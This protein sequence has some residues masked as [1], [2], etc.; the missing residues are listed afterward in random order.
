MTNTVEDPTANSV[1]GTL[2]V[3]HTGA[4]GTLCDGDFGSQDV[5][6]RV[7]SCVGFIKPLVNHCPYNL[8][9][10]LLHVSCLASSYCMF[11]NLKRIT[12]RILHYLAF[13]SVCGI[14]SYTEQFRSPY[15][16]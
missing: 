3:F 12:A 7:Q 2:Q 4:W 5:R 8:Q 16:T 15:G 1:L 6:P 13:T 11:A 14:T 10:V 9:H